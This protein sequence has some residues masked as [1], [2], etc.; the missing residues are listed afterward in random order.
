MPIP[1]QL[2][3]FRQARLATLERVAPLS[4][5][6]LDFSPARRKWSVGEVM[7]HLVRV[8]ATYRSEI[9]E[10]IR[11]AESGQ[12]P[13]LKRSFKDID[14]SIFHLPKA[15]LP[16]LEI[17]FTISSR[18]MPRAVGA[19]VASSRAIPIQNPAA[20]TPVAG[21]PA[22][23]L[24]RDL[25]AS[26]AAMEALFA[27]HPSLDYHQLIHQ[28][29]LFGV[30]DVTQLLEILTLHERR[31]QAQIAEILAAPAFPQAA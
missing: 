1:T 29:P 12:K 7:D 15:L 24:A 21:R 8:E 26:L 31:H 22:A 10:L 20:A 9:A 16:F 14:V 30:N 27:A 28:H 4:Q 23:D 25:R 5:Q 18:L 11:L 17:P 2:D 19:F 13:F 3:A 6:Q